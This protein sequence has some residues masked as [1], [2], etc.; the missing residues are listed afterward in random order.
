MPPR[1]KPE[2]PFEYLDRIIRRH[3]KGSV[4]GL[5]FIPDV[6]KSFGPGWEFMLRKGAEEGRFELRPESGLSRLSKDEMR[7][8]IPGPSRTLL[9]W[10]RT[11]R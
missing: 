7:L 9:S 6:A 10:V 11:R 8:C 4:G 3:S 1:A 5:A 2:E